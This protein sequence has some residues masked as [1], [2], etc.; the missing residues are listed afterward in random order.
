MHGH[1]RRPGAL[2]GHDGHPRGWMSARWIA[3]ARLGGGPGVASQP[4][5]PRHHRDEQEQAAD[6][7][8]DQA[9]PEPCLVA[10][11]AAERVGVRPGRGGYGAADR[12]ES[13]APEGELD[14]HDARL[15]RVHVS[16]VRRVG[17]AH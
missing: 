4:R 1:G 9:E 10:R 13:D 6:P 14:Q 17:P 11:V 5:S 2:G 8:D 12:D 3:G 15:L 7:G 16:V